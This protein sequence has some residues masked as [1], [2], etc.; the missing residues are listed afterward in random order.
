[1][2]NKDIGLLKGIELFKDLTDDELSKVL[3]LSFIKDYPAD[4]TLFFENTVGDIMYVIIAGEVELSKK[5][6]TGENKPIAVA[7]D[8]DFF[9]EMS[10]IDNELRSA[11]ARVGK[12]SKL[13]VVTRRAFER[14]L[15]VDPH[16]T[17]KLLMSFLRSLSKRL[18]TKK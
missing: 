5:A 3:T 9:G 10:L 12:P 17:S 2:D 14:M 15:E 4:N 13:L 7:H 1:M 11:T 6:D 16:I 18:R 8:G